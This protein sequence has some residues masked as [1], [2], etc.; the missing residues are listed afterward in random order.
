[1]AT[2]YSKLLPRPLSPEMTRPFWEAAT[3]HELV[4]PR[5]K[6]CDPLFFYPRSG[7][8]AVYPI[9]SNG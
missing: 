8:R 1:M 4:M 2:A 7:A 3:H 5:C 6:L 9:I